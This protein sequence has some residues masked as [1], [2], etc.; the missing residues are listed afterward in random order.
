MIITVLC[1]CKRYSFEVPVHFQNAV[2]SFTNPVSLVLTR[3]QSAGSY[4]VVLNLFIAVG[5]FESLLNPT[6][7]S[8]RILAP[9]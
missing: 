4:F 2:S 1:N 8:H 3:I 6:G 7:P 5:P 9:A